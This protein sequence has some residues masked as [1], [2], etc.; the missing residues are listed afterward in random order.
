MSGL[1]VTAAGDELELRLRKAFDGRLNGELRSALDASVTLEAIAEARPLVVAIGP[2]V[3]QEQAI[4]LA[5]TID[6]LHPDVS[7]VLMTSP[8]PLLWEQ[9]LRAGVRDIVAPDAPLV[10]VR[11]SFERALDTAHR[12]RATLVP[13]HLAGPT[14]KVIAIVSPKGGVGKTAVASNLAVGLAQRAPE[15]VVVVDLDL[16]FGD[17]ASAL[18]LSPDQTIADSAQATTPVDATTIKAYL[19]PHPQHL[20]ALCAPN[21]PALADDV[22]PEHTGHVLKLLADEFRY[23]VVDTSAGLDWMTIAA[24]EHATDVVLVAGTDVASARSMRKELDAFDL[25]GYTKQQRHFV[26]NRADAKVGLGTG[27]IALTVG[28]EAAVQIPSA[29]AVALSM[30]QGVPI[31]ESA[32]RSPVGRALDELVNRVAFDVNVPRSDLSS[33]TRFRRRKETQ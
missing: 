30:N 1:L 29:R 3:T 7:V 6:R 17:I 33:G 18:R 5:G 27:D 10:E 26:L 25:L 31:L 14:S 24:M 16:Q 22:D 21:S 12:R 20:F 28:F 32:P 9:A 11:A 4:E 2:S 8:T 13:E 15:Q 23:V 19:T